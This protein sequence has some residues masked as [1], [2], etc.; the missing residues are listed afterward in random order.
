MKTPL[1]E[2]MEYMEQNQYFIGMI[3]WLSI[4]NLLKKRNKSL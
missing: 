2:L 3:Y 1:Q 4:M